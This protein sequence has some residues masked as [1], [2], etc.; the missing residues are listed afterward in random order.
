MRTGTLRRHNM[1]RYDHRFSEGLNC[2][3]PLLR[4]PVCQHLVFWHVQGQVVTFLPSL[5]KYG[6][7][8]IQDLR[9]YVK[10]LLTL[11]P[12]SVNPGALQSLSELFHGRICAC[13]YGDANA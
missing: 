13:D 8:F 1:V 6:H 12:V 4:E 11:S 9:Y 5:T 10:P 2:C 3:P 7:L